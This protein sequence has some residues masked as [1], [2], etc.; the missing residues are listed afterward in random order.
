[1]TAIPMTVKIRYAKAAGGKPE[2]NPPTVSNAPVT[3]MNMDKRAGSLV[4]MNKAAAMKDTGINSHPCP[5]RAMYGLNV[6]FQG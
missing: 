3:I 1:M 4:F 5:K 2:N 6:V